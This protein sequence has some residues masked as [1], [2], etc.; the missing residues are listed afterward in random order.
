MKVNW[1]LIENYSENWFIMDHAWNFWKYSWTVVGK[2]W[3]NLDVIAP[4]KHARELWRRAH[5]IY[6]FPTALE[7][8]FEFL[9]KSKNLNTLRHHRRSIQLKFSLHSLT[10]SKLLEGLLVTP[11]NELRESEVGEDTLDRHECISCLLLKLVQHFGS[12]QHYAV[13]PFTL[14]RAIEGSNKAV[15]CSNG[16]KFHWMYFRRAVVHHPLLSRW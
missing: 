16:L 8:N 3:K 2:N 14:H 15:G 7:H 10:C 12:S 6:T 13:V 4:H 5:K 9:L 11:W 1:R